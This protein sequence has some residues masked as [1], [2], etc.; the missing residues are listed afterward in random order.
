MADQHPPG[1]APEA[2]Q[3]DFMTHDWQVLNKVK[4]PDGEWRE[5]SATTTGRKYINGCAIIDEYEATLP[6]GSQ[7]SGMTVRSFNEETKEWS[8][9][10]L[11]DRFPPDLRPVVGRFKADGT[12][13]F[14]QE[15]PT[16]EAT[17][18]RFMWDNIT[19]TTAR[20]QQAFSYDGG[21]TWDTN[22]IMEFTR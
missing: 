2:R 16:P 7:R 10:W 4:R 19:D 1:E 21:K 12:G 6:D 5:F 22:W 15:N 20:W 9:V 13:I 8:L 3:F 11:D 18:L 17:H 14:M